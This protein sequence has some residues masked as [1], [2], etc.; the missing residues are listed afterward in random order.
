MKKIALCIAICS[1]TI[2]IP[3]ITAAD[4]IDMYDTANVQPNV[5]IIFDDSLSMTY[6]VPYDING[7]YNGAYDIAKN[8]RRQCLRWG[9]WRCLSW[10]DWEEYTGTFTDNNNDGIHDSD[11]YIRSGHRLNFDYGDYDNR[12]GV[13]KQ[14][15]KDIIDQSK[16]HVRFGIM[17]LTAED[18]PSTGTDEY[19]YDTTV[20]DNTYGGAVIEDRTHAEIE[21]LKG[22]IDN[23]TADGYTPLA[24]RLVNAGEYFAGNFG[25]AS[26]I[27]AVNWCR[28]NYVIL[29]TDGEPTAEGDQCDDATWDLDNVAGDFDHIENWFS[30]KGV[31]ANYDGNGNDPNGAAYGLGGS[32]YLDDVA[33][34]LHDVEDS[35]DPSHAIEGNQ[36]LTIYTIG[37]HIDNQLLEDTADN[38][39]GEYYTAFSTHELS[40][41]LQTVMASIIEQTQTFTAPVVPVQRTTSGNKMY[42]SLFTPK[43]HDNFWPGYLMKLHIGSDGQLYANDEST[44][45]ADANGNLIENL[46]NPSVSPNP[47][48]EAHAVLKG[49]NLDNRNIYTYLGSTADLNDASNEFV[50]TNSTINDTMLDNPAKQAYGE[51]ATTAREDLMRYLR[52]YDSYDEDGDL[53]Y[54]EKRENIMGDIL[55]SRPL[56]IDYVID[57]EHPENNVR[58]IYVGT[59]DGMLHA[60]DDSDGS[61]KWA[62]IPPD[63]LPKLKDIV[64]ES[65]HQ[66]Y[67]DSSPQ[68]YIKDVDND[69][70][71]EEGD[72]DQVIIVFGERRGGT[73]YCALDVTNPDDPQFLWRIDNIDNSSTF[74]IPA[75]TLVISGMGQTWSEPAIGTVKVGA[76][77]KNVAIVGGG[78]ST[79][80]SAGCALY[81]INIENGQLHKS[82]TSTEHANLTYSIPC[83]PLAVDTTFDGYINR[84]YVGDMGGQMWR[85]GLQRADAADTALEVGEVNDWTPRR[86]FQGN[87]GTKIFYPPDMVLEPGYAYLYFGTGDRADP[88]NIPSPDPDINRFYAVKDKNEP[89][90]SFTTQTEADLVNVTNDEL[91]DPAVD[92]ATKQS[93]R[94]QLASGDGWYIILDNDGEKALAPPVAIYGIVLFTTFTPVSDPCSYG[95]DG[96]LYAM[97]YLTAEAVWDFDEDSDLDRSDRSSVI[98]YGIPT[99]VVITI[100]ADGVTRL[101]VAV[102]GKIFIRNFSSGSSGFTINSWREVF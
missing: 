31:A 2:I 76:A 20:L 22:Y 60:F 34:Y 80:N 77:V 100:G 46:W 49:M 90:D 87:S 5:L 61:E 7:T 102:G 47:Y 48:W 9:W 54:N 72:G 24:N 88:M 18:A 74:G 33:K 69:G 64:E 26:P 85:F 39:G 15:I 6:G 32:D 16:D 95:G 21:T 12:L 57:Y 86:L 82:F 37:F 30:S 58:V 40:I 59:N 89:N 51:A 66:Y 44:P 27:D 93:I 62:F 42:I 55:H 92:E 91:Q 45:A 63:L 43:T 96:R 29:M 13:A 65:G 56:L 53:V 67:V 36:N 68:A 28:K 75:P 14:A 25:H 17:V 97:N 3:L 41:K 11:S 81:V 84:V 94:S 99:E 70:N 23:M 8:Y 19:H 10:S 73:S 98:G 52:G 101:Y 4:D 50:T 38:G 71:I 83:T 78:Y 1:I 79:D 35:L